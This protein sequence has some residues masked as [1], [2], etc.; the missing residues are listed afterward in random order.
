MMFGY[1]I[2]RRL[3]PLVRFFGRLPDWA[4]R[5]FAAVLDA[6]T[7]P[8][9]FVN[10]L[11]SWAGGTVLSSARTE[12]LLEAT[13]E[14]LHRELGGEDGASLRRAMHFPVGW[15][16]YFK[17]TMTLADVYHY[18]TQHFDHHRAQLTLDLD[19]PAGTRVVNRNRWR[20]SEAMKRPSPPARLLR[21]IVQRLGLHPDDQDPVEVDR[22]GR[23]ALVIATNHSALDI[24]K[25]TGVT[26]QLRMRPWLE[27]G[28]PP[29]ATRTRGRS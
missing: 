27:L 18:G 20:G 9:H 11:G 6:A 25:P 13:I 19:I 10:Y 1:L 15:N 28:Q 21:K 16:P 23:R 29:P 7:Q 17:E 2:V 26:S 8:F 12:R 4:S 22:T 3:L 14:A 24:G 5:D